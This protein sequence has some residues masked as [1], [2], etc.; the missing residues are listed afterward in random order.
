[1]LDSTNSIVNLSLDDQG[2][3]ATI[4]GETTRLR[5]SKNLYAFLHEMEDCVF[6]FDES[7]NTTKHRKLWA[8]QALMQLNVLHGLNMKG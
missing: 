7:L 6:I 5:S 1:M 3:L 2:F 4:D 8:S